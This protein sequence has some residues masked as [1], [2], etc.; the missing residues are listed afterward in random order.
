MKTNILY[1]T[2][3]LWMALT[4]F[5]GCADH[6]EGIT[7]DE[8]EAVIPENP[9]INVKNK[10]LLFDAS[11]VAQG[12]NI[13]AVGSNWKAYPG[14][15]CPWL[16]QISPAEGEAG[17]NVI[18]VTL[19][20]N[21]GMEER[22]TF[23]VIKH[24]ESGDTVH[25]DIKQYT[26]ESKYTRETDSLALVAIYQAL[27]SSN[28]WMTPWDMKKPITTWAGLE[29]AEVR[30]EQRVVGINTREFQIYGELPNELGNLRELKKLAITSGSITGRIP[31]TITSLRKLEEINIPFKDGYAEWYV[32]ENAGDMKALR[33]LNVSYLKIAP[34]FFKNLYKIPTLETINMKAFEGDLPE[35]I[36][37]LVN[38]KTLA[39]G[40]TKVASLPQDMGNLPNLEKLDLSN[41]SKLISLGDHLGQLPKLTSLNLAYCTKLITLPDNIGQ[42]QNL[43]TLNING[44]S[45]LEAIPE[46]FGNLNRLTKLQ[47]RS[48]SSLI[49]L[50]ESI[51]NLTGV[52]EIEMSMCNGLRSFPEGLGNLA[53]LK[54][55][56]FTTDANMVALPSTFGNLSNL[57]EF[58]C[59]KYSSD[60]FGVS[61]DM[62]LFRNLL[63]LKSLKANYNYFSG[64]LSVLAGLP[65][66]TTIEL[67]GNKLSGTLDLSQ[68]LNDKQAII[69]LSNNGLSGTLNGITKGTALTKLILNNNKLT[70]ELPADIDL[71]SKLTN[72]NLA[73]NLLTGNLPIALININFTWS[74]LV[75]KNNNMSGTIDPQI[76]GSTGWKSKW[77]PTTNII[78]QNEGY[79]FSGF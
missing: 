6:I 71:C 52:T 41:C 66:L 8:P 29:F 30:G 79:E 27:T 18:G 26:H 77:Y 17:N 19:A 70:G 76:I 4:S 37:T 3:F 45:A 62:S 72:L 23:I 20:L 67:A 55:F 68:I 50:P 64:D 33:I 15:T 28:A 46:S 31:V 39:L 2:L 7:P 38:L 1:L 59:S 44:C 60:N 42:L 73:D 16:T 12:I 14:E 13:R 48:C 9:G 54:K 51:G 34:E 36:S 78:P 65:Q 75:L 43:T 57:E 63:K 47:L 40:Y 56:T 35:G 32:P 25:V 74:G 11:G 24:E 5:W 49:G 21:E 69:N 10:K 22:S 58:D 61:G 53:N